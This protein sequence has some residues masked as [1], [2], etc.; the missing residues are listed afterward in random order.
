MTSISLRAWLAF[1]CCAALA[2]VAVP[3]PA[4]TKNPDALWKIV[5]GK[6]RPNMAASGQPAPCTLYD[7]AHGF[8]LLKDISGQGQFLLIPTVRTTGIEAEPLLSAHTPNYFAQAWDARARVGKA[9]GVALPPDD[10]MLAINSS[11]GR[12]QNQLHIH[13]DCIRPEIKTALY[14]MRHEIGRT[15]APLPA[16]L[17]GHTYRAIRIDGTSLDGVYPFRLLAASLTDPQQEMGRHT[18]ALVPENYA[19]GYGFVLL[20]DHVDALHH[21]MASA[22]ELQDHACAVIAQ[23]DRIHRPG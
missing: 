15:W 16:P 9:Y 21:D 5:D 4:N 19:G 10:V 11:Q 20:D 18:L 3:R 23:D 7:A 12:S 14:F 8:A 22:E 1:A 17:A 13:I 6:C 2:I